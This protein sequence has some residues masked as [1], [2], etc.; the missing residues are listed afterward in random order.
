MAIATESVLERAVQEFQNLRDA[1]EDTPDGRRR[2]ELD[3]E[4][5][6][7]YAQHSDDLRKAKPPE[8]STE[9]NRI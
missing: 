1:A 3:A 6:A 8:E 7:F 4:I 2:L 5:K 9:G